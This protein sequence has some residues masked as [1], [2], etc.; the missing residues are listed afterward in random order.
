MNIYVGATYISWLNFFALEQNIF[1]T[2]VYIY[3]IRLLYK[4]KFQIIA[5]QVITMDLD[6]ASNYWKS[7]LCLHWHHRMVLSTESSIWENNSKGKKELLL[8]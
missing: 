7:L 1:Y 6:I 3:N 8:G 5:A 4:R 2:Y